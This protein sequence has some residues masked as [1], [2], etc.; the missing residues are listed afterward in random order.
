MVKRILIDG[1]HP[2]E[3]RV[4]VC[5]NNQIKEV[6]YQ[7]SFKK[8]IKSNVYLAKVERVEAALQVAFVNYGGNRHGFLPF[9]EIHPDYYQIPKADKEALLKQIQEIAEAKVSKE[10]TQQ[11]LD[12][13]EPAEKNDE[14]MES[15]DGEEDGIIQQIVSEEPNFARPEFYK[16]YKIQEVIKKDQVILVQIT[17]EERGNKGASLTTYLSLA[18]RYC[19]LMPN[20]T[21]AGGVSRKITDQEDR[22]RLRELVEEFHQKSEGQASVVIRTAGAYKTK[23]EIRKDF[24]YLSRLW[25][26]IRQHTLASQAPAFIHEE[27]DVI[28]RTI[29]DTYDSDIDEII[30]AGEDAYKSAFEFIKQILPRHTNKLKKHSDAIPI[31]SKYG[32]EAE[33]SGLYSNIVQLDSGGYLVITATEALIAIDVNSGRAIR[34]RNAENTALAT[35][36]EA[37]KEAAYQIMLRDLSGIIVIDFIDMNEGRNRRAVEDSFRN[38]M[39]HDRARLQVGKI[40]NLGLLTLSRQRLKYSFLEYNMQECGHCHGRGSVRVVG[41]TALVVLRAIQDELARS[42]GAI[43][44]LNVSASEGLIF[45][46]LNRK[47]KELYLLEEQNKCEIELSVD[48]EAGADGFFIEAADVV[49]S[50]EKSALSAIDVEPYQKVAADPEAGEAKQGEKKPRHKEKRRK[51]DNGFEEKKVDEVEATSL[52][53]KNSKYKK[54]QRKRFK[55]GGAK[56]NNT[57]IPIQGAPEFDQTESDNF[58]Q[59]MH[60]KQQ[61]NQSLLREIWKK[62]VE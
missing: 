22:S 55:K 60:S 56:E 45:Y 26:N 54:T 11:Q 44:K 41:A 53:S 62:I 42:K 61:Q 20:S 33:V 21:R 31:F 25:N 49:I 15:S 36:L 51:T 9:S 37:A 34:E 29:R 5:E 1:A 10:N 17:K 28:K 8:S 7:S 3:L 2:E 19:V 18:G 40:N 12:N 30:I 43:K 52:E 27:G 4:A 57:P 47:R 13:A 6:D 39:T 59:D 48:N 32:I 46:L 16:K 24:D 50:K 38:H 14:N 58:E 35:N 23:A